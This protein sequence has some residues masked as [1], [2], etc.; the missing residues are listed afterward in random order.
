VVSGATEDD[1]PGGWD[2]DDTIDVMVLV[3]RSQ[4]STPLTGNWPPEELLDEYVLGLY[5]HLQTLEN[6][7]TLVVELDEVPTEE[8]YPYNIYG[9][10]TNVPSAAAWTR[11][12]NG[13][14][15]T[16]EARGDSIILTGRESR[17]FARHELEEA[18]AFTSN[19]LDALPT[20][21]P[22]VGVTPT[23][24]RQLE[25]VLGAADS[26]VY[27][28]T[29]D[30]EDRALLQAAV[31]TLRAQLSSP[32]PDRHIIGRTLKRFA[33]IGGGIA[34]G[35]LGNYGSDL[36]RHFHVPWP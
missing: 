8:D 22:Q 27:E 12:W 25:V 11:S 36:L 23:E 3:D 5:T 10:V 17:A 6:R 9:V 16:F 29:L 35:V 34:I 31:D 33:S 7:A 13:G 28:M 4:L 24:H 18:L 2:Q 21:P 19:E 26:A 14:L 1:E 32:E 30:P 15:V 20:E